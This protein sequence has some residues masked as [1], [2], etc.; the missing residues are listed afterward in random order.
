MFGALDTNGRGN[1]FTLAYAIEW[2]VVHGADVINLSLGADSDS[3]V[4]HNAINYAIEHNVIVV[5]A[6][7]NLNVNVPQFPASYPGVLGVTAVNAD[8]SKADFAAFGTGWIDLAAPGVGITSTIIGPLGRGYASWSG[9]SMSAGFVSGA[10]ALLRQRQPMASVVA[11]GAQLTKHAVNVDP[12]NPTHVGEL[13]GL[14]NVA[15]AMEIAAV[16][17]TPTPVP[18]TTPTPT[19]TTPEPTA[20]PLPVTALPP[21]NEPLNLFYYL[22]W[23]SR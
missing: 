12:Q 23:V 8:N 9:T 1:T 2:A 17:A 22:P 6:A 14:L 21:E 16:D 13:G 19:P 15:A 3:Q 11:I 7:G 20:T 4:L 10:A 18:E 5:A